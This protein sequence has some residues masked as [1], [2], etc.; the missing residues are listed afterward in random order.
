MGR[1]GNTMLVG[2]EPELALD[3]ELGEVVRFYLTNTANTRV[4]NVGLQGARM[5][6]VGGDSGRCEHEEFVDEVLLAPSERAVVDV[7]FDK[8]GRVMLEHHHPDRCYTLATITVDEK[9]AAPSLA[10]QFEIRRSNADMVAERDRIVPFLAAAPDKT[11]AFVAE[12]DMGVPEGAV[13]YTCPMH[14]EVVSAEEGSCPQCGMK[15]LATAAPVTYSCPMHP[16]VVSAEEGACPECGMKL[17]AAAITYACPMHPEVVSDTPGRCP[18]C[19]MKLLPSQF[20]TRTAPTRPP[21]TSTTARDDGHEHGGE[22]H[23]HESSGGIEWEDDMVEVNKMTTPANMSWKIV[24]RTAD[25]EGGAPRTM[26]ST[27]GSRSVTR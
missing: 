5:K 9:Q 4:F 17:L 19:G 3:A 18:E 25:T 27:G 11:L 20:V 7:L 10:E 21:R 8:P 24:D 23:G 12:M 2:G 16:E 14:P 6:L 26:R 13:V 15:L 22:G 1:F